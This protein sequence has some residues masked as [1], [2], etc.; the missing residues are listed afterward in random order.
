MKRALIV[1]IVHNPQDSRI[2]HREINALV[3]AGWH[4]TYAAP[5]TGYDLEVDSATH[6]SL[7][8]IDLPR[9]SG[10][11]RL[12]AL[13]AARKLL[14]RQ[15]REHDVVVLH[16]PELLAALPG[17]RLSNAVWDV[18]EDTAAAVT[19]KPWLPGPLRPV[20]SWVFAK[21][22][23]SAE[24]RVHLLLAEYAYQKRFQEQHL[25]VPNVTR[26]P[27]TVP[28][29]DQPRAV[30]AGSLTRKRGV[31]EMIEAARIITAKTDGAVRVELMGKPGPEVEELLTTAVADG[32][33]DWS[34]FVPNDQAMERIEGSIAGLTLLH[35][36]PN[37]R[38]SLPTKV[39]D[40]IAHGVPVVTTPLP[41]GKELVEAS[42]SGV[43]VPFNDPE[44][45]AEAVIDLW[46]SPQK[47]RAMGEAGHRV[48]LE[49]YNWDHHAKTFVDELARVGG[50]ALGS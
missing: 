39:T 29:P 45:V 50:S 3:D 36:E 31:E 4:V 1:T 21:V 6:E 8:H 27:E 2:R 19:L 15:A 41:L 28:P 33:V 7:T 37:Y 44:A 38:I 49:K 34:G 46:N 22:E 12:N 42:D 40:Y 43:I 20:V 30:Y 5:F 18:H 48:A 17:L 9:A 13:R 10:R 24:K 35:D 11:R 32:V 26:V 14:R 23:R 47:R 25:V 16:D